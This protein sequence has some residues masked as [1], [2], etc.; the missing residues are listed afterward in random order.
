MIHRAAVVALMGL[1]A[2]V[3]ATLAH[4]GEHDRFA[5]GYAKPIEKAHGIENW[6]SKKAISY[7]IEIAFGGNVIF[8]GHSIFEIGAERVRLEAEDGTV[9]VWDGQDAWYTPA[10]KEFK[11][12]PPRFHL[13]T[14]TY[15][16]SVPFKLRDPG[17][18]LH[19]LPDAPLMDGKYP[20]LKRAK[21]TFGEDVG[22]APDDWY[23]L[24]RQANT[25]RLAAMSYIV[26]YSKSAEQA[27]KE[28]HAIVYKGYERFEGVALSTEW[29]FHH[30]SADKG[31]FGEP[32]GH[33]KITNVKFIDPPAGAFAKPDD[34]ARDALPGE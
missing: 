8:S 21:L 22:D 31:V 7:D 25:D 5:A 10:D 11:G 16:L 20:K 9:M 1:L 24:Y 13:R 19:E 27:E 30:W 32:I 33:V 6:K 2:A 3:S 18:H 28:P 23:V 29:D 17:A 4:E 14:W 12:P 34:A 26:T 15:F